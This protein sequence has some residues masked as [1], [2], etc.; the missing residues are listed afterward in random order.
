MSHQSSQVW[1]GEGKKECLRATFNTYNNNVVV[2]EVRVDVA[3]GAASK[4]RDRCSK[5]G[6]VNAGRRRN[7]QRVGDGAVAREEPDTDGTRGP[8]HGIHT[9]ATS[10]EVRA[11]VVGRDRLLR[12]PGAAAASA[13]V[14]RC[15]HL[16]A[17]YLRA[18]GHGAALVGVEG[19]LVGRLRVDA[20]DDVDLARAR[21]VRAE[22]PQRG[23]RAAPDGHVRDVGDEE[24]VGVGLVGRD[25]RGGAPGGRVAGLVVGAEVD[26]A[27]GVAGQARCG[28]GG[29]ALVVDEAVG[30][31]RAGVEGELVKEVGACVAVLERVRGGCGQPA[32]G[33]E[34]EQE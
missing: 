18:L 1:E 15:Q 34:G 11:K 31:V 14:G 3:P 20:L 10:I 26:A 16:G 23:P 24:H 17:G 29:G 13:T 5:A 7:R 4:L 33:E 25:A 12:A 32:G 8:L 27:L 30:G 9:A 21:P 22:A 28:G 19:D 2:L 6:R